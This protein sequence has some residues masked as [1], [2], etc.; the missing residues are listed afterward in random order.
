MRAAD[1][2]LDRPSD[3]EAYAEFV[4]YDDEQ[5]DIET[6]EV[7]KI[8]QEESNDDIVLSR[9]VV[10]IQGALLAAM[11]AIGFLLGAVFGWLIRPTFSDSVDFTVRL[12]GKVSYIT[13]DNQSEPDVGSVIVVLPTE[14][15]PDEKLSPSALR[16]DQPP[17]GRRHSSVMVIDAIGGAFTRADSRGEYQLELSRA[18]NYFVLLISGNRKRRRGQQ[19]A[20]ADV[21]Q[22]GRYFLFPT[23]LLGNNEYRWFQQEIDGALRR[24][25]E[26]SKD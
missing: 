10:Y 8:L 20:S 7:T 11:A 14:R 18:G 26:F 24:D 1:L 21:A 23:Q 19:P 22:L 3:E 12:T 13:R 16:P 25:I 15:R 4:V 2:A 6:G 9:R 17:P 5:L